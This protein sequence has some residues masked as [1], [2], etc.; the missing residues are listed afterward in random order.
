MKLLLIITIAA[1]IL[2]SCG[3]QTQAN[4]NGKA[5]SQTTKS[6]LVPGTRLSIVPPAGFHLASSFVGLEDKNGNA[7][8]VIDLTMGNFYTNAAT[9]SPEGLAAEGAEV[10]AY[11]DT[12]VAGFP[13]KI[14]LIQ[15]NSG[16]KSY[17]LALA[18]PPLAQWL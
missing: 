13:A 11:N 16:M 3:P 17:M 15:A 9:M 4:G 18:I 12:T 6:V 7:V 5:S 2:N 10:L 8:Q 14:A 1:G